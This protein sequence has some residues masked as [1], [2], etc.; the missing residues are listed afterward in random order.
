MTMIKFVYE[1]NQ[2]QAPIVRGKHY[3]QFRNTGISFQPRMANYSIPNK[4]LASYIEGQKV[5]NFIIQKTNKDGCLVLGF[6][7]DIVNSPYIGFGVETDNEIEHDHFYKNDTIQYKFV[8]SFNKQDSQ[9]L[10]EYNLLKYFYRLELD[11]IYDFMT[12]KS[13]G[14]TEESDNSKT[15]NDKLVKNIEEDMKKIEISDKLDDPRKLLQG[16]KNSKFEVKIILLS[17]DLDN[18]SKKKKFKNIFDII[19]IGFLSK[20]V[21]SSLSNLIKNEDSDIF[22]ESNR[23]KYH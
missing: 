3:L 15:V 18:I 9:D 7:G 11:E 23:F 4:T 10:S 19:S 8:N 2:I 12:K 17:G 13:E 14:E 5:F 22:I 6:W 16:F 21:L 1:L 20:N